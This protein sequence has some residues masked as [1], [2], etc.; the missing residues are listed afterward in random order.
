MTLKGY[1]KPNGVTIS[2]DIC[3]S[4]SLSSSHPFQPHL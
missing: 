4:S 2:G 1:I 3:V